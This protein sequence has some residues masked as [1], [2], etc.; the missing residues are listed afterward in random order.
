MMASSFGQL[1]RFPLLLATFFIFGLPVGH[2]GILRA[3]DQSELQKRFLEEAPPRWQAYLAHDF[4][5]QGPLSGSITKNGKEIL[6]TRMDFKQRPGHRLV[7]MR[8]DNFEDGAHTDQLY[9]YNPDYVFALSRKGEDKP[10]ALTELVMRTSDNS[11]EASMTYQ[12][13]LKKPAQAVMLKVIDTSLLDL[14]QLPSFRVIRIG[15]VQRGGEKLVEI[16]FDNPNDPN[17]SSSCPIQGGRMVLDPARSWCVREYD[18]RTQHVNSIGTERTEAIELRPGTS[19]AFPLP[20]K[21]IT[22]RQATSTTSNRSATVRNECVCDLDEARVPAEEQFH[23]SAFG[24]PE[25]PGLKPKGPHWYIWAACGAV[26]AFAL[27][28]ALRWLGRRS[29]G[30]TTR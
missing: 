15:E 6:Q 26:A 20:A 7:E 23:L 21:I 29:A 22:T 27:A 10:W 2:P 17:Q 3:D 14:V 4:S 8:V 30:S 13:Y 1:A 16:E 9:A 19:T 18:V 25:P 11:L 12:R 28:F 5:F 24:L